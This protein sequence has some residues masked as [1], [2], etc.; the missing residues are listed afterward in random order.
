[1]I[2]PVLLLYFGTVFCIQNGHDVASENEYPFYVM[3]GNPHIC[4]GTLI[5]YDPALI[6]TAA[7]CVDA[8]IH[9]TNYTKDK[10][11]YFALYNDIH[12]DKQKADAIIDWNV[13]P[14]YNLSGN[15]DVKYDAAIV[16][17]ETPIKKSSRTKRAPFW[18]TSLSPQPSKGELLYIFFLLGDLT[19]V[20]I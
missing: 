11:P 13:H 15:I 19:V 9:P 6:L 18:S 3:I 17:L 4:G 1:M 7:H 20:V 12:R 8:P 5:S 2:L 14:L 16:R 10:N